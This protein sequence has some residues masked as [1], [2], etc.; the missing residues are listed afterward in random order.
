MHLSH[1]HEIVIDQIIPDAYEDSFAVVS[2]LGK[3]TRVVTVDCASTQQVIHQLPFNIR[4]ITSSSSHFVAIT[5]DWSLVEFGDNVQRVAEEGSSARGLHQLATSSKNTLFQD[6][7]GKLAFASREAA[8]AAVN[9]SEA[10]TIRALFDG[11]SYM[12]PPMESMFDD[13]MGGFMHERLEDV[14]DEVDGDGD[15]DMDE[16]D[17]PPIPTKPVRTVGKEEM[18]AF[19]ELFKQT[20]LQ[21]MILLNNFELY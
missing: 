8:P 1:R 5:Q 15:V 18:V 6:I 11:P 19:V 14:I 4:G 12:M 17:E 2:R 20:S 3:R 13:A 9:I 7:F 21:R 10:S 16:P